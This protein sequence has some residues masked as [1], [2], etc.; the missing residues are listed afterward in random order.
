MLGTASLHL[1]AADMDEQESAE[2]TTASA[3]CNTA[4]TCIEVAAVTC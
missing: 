1:A 3:G 4:A 2:E